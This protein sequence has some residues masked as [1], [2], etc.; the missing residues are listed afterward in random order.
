MCG[1]PERRIYGAGADTQVRPY[2]AAAYFWIYGD[3]DK[4]KWKDG[5]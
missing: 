3:Y 5:C 4:G 2:A 1:A